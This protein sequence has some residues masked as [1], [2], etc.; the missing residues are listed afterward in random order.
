MRALFG[1]HPWRAFGL[2]ASGLLIAAATQPSLQFTGFY[3]LEKLGWRPSQYSAMF[4]VGGAVGILGNVAAGRMGDRFGRKVVGFTLL[5]LFPIA[6]FAFYRGSSSMVVAAWVPLVFCFMGSRV[7]L[8]AL[9]VELFPTS[10]RS[11]AAGVYA[12]MEAMGA[13]AGLFVIYVFRTSELARVI[14]LVALLSL[15]TAAVLLSFPETRRRE[16]EEI[17]G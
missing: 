9:S 12:V 13:V 5:S 2:A 15:G 16:L 14:P 3:T 7:V 1:T 4:V 10:F 6:S 8:K 11:A 17:S